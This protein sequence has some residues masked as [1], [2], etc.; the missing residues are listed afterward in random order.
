MGVS[1]GSEMAP[2]LSEKATRSN[3]G[4]KR[5]RRAQPSSPPRSR[6]PGSAE[7]RFA[8]DGEVSAL[9]QLDEDGIGE[10][11]GPRT[12]RHPSDAAR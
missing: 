3:S 8:A 6:E 11:Q 10:G 4:T 5:P 12:S 7:K 2:I 1:T 9:P